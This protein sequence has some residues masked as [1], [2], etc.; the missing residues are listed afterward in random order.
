MKQTNENKTNPMM[1]KITHPHDRLFKDAFGHKATMEDFL[2]HRLPKEILGAIDLGTLTI[3]KTDFVKSNLKKSLCDMLY[4]VRLRGSKDAYLYILLEAQSTPDPNIHTRLLEYELAITK[5]HLKQGHKKLPGVLKFVVYTGKQPQK[6]SPMPPTI[7][8]D[9]KKHNLGA[10]MVHFPTPIVLQHEDDNYIKASAGKGALAK[11]LLKHGGT[12]HFKSFFDQN[13]KPIATLMNT[14]GYSKT[15]FIYICDQHKSDPKMVLE[16]LNLTPKAKQ[17]IM[18]GLQRMRQ[19][20]M[21]LGI[22]QGMEKI[23]LEFVREGI[24]TEEKAKAV[25]EKME[26]EGA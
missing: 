18:T 2:K 6:V 22:Q 9:L 13:P 16:K 20:S 14:S 10:W 7:E 15:A 17:E 4:S 5:M 1:E 24:V 3:E 11:L 26:K 12:K 25:L 8:D 21:E 23:A 19:Q